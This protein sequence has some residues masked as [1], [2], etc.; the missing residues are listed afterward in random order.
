[1]SL[2]RLLQ[3]MEPPV[4]EEPSVLS[5]TD[6]SAEF[7]DLKADLDR[8]VAK[9][10]TKPARKY[11]YAS[12]S[13]W[14]CVREEGIVATTGFDRTNNINPERVVLMRIGTA[15]HRALTDEWLGPAGLL[16]GIWGCY[17]CKFKTEPMSP[18]FPK[19]PTCGRVQ[20]PEYVEQKFVDEDI[21]L[22]GKPDGFIPVKNINPEKKKVGTLEMK[23]A[24]GDEIDSLVAPKL[25][26]VWQAHAGMHLA[27]VAGFDT[28]A[29][30]IVYISKTVRRN[31]AFDG[32]PSP[33]KVFWVA[34]NPAITAEIIA[35]ARAL[36]N[37]WK[38]VN[39][40]IVA[41]KEGAPSIAWPERTRCK[42]KSDGRAKWC[43]VRD[44][45]FE[46]IKKA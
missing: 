14:L 20:Q 27:R 35:K 17:S 24:A 26:H 8:I 39:E 4:V 46:K 12:D 45:C 29:A 5:S 9:N 31:G 43:P 34:E 23:S 6:V 15:L 10:E 44:L 38:V 7:P 21:K 36:K 2:I 1:M 33:F 42:T 3:E 28:S 32:A 11:L 22:V 13:S 25:D 40:W 30:A 18:W 19:C 41:G 37:M 16:Y